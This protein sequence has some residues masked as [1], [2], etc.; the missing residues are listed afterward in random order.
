MENIMNAS[1][2]KKS[3]EQE[4]LGKLVQ[5]TE[6]L[7]GFEKDSVGFVT[8]L[9]YL[10]QTG[11]AEENFVAIFKGI[12][13]KGFFGLA[14]L[15]KKDF[16]RSVRILAPREIPPP[17]IKISKYEIELGQVK[18]VTLYKVEIHSENIF[19]TG[20]C[21]GK[22]HVET[23]LEGVAA[24]LHALRIDAKIPKL[25]ED[26]TKL[27]LKKSCAALDDDFTF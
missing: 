27:L 6:E 3:W 24:T 10:N 22:G 9:R 19:G 4:V 25:P 23:F 2:L 16:E 20:A 15:T 8:E 14:E 18:P 1:Q 12:S 21:S 11:T 5:F 26:T 7:K 13:P 17:K